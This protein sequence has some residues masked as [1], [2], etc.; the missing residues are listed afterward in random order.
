MSICSGVVH[1]LVCPDVERPFEEAVLL[2]DEIGAESEEKSGR[3]VEPS[4]GETGSG[5][6][7]SREGTVNA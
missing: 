1:A 2:A 6:A 3:I 7:F 5:R 4:S